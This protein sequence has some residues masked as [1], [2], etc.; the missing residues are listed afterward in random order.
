[1]PRHIVWLLLRFEIEPVKDHS[2]TEKIC[3]ESSCNENFDENRLKNVQKIGIQLFFLWEFILFCVIK[4][5]KTLE[6]TLTTM[7][8]QCRKKTVFDKNEMSL[9]FQ[10]SE[11]RHYG[12]SEAQFSIFLRFW[13]STIFFVGVYSLLCD[14]TTENPWKYINYYE[15]P[16][17]KKNSFWQ[18]WFFA[19][20]QAPQS[21]ISVLRNELNAKYLDF[22]GADTQK[23]SW[24]TTK[25]YFHDFFFGITNL[26]KN[27]DFK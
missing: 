4:L 3:N 27:L 11:V 20:F 21:K 16:M 6:N 2:K 14:K 24:K 26:W 19:D 12:C 7:N 22:S 8:F 18:K 5:Q 10:I 15:F 23:R 13:D 25:K 17:P 9:I 1:M